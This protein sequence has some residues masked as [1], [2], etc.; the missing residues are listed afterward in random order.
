MWLYF[1]LALL[2]ENYS[3][4]FVMYVFRAYDSLRMGPTSSI[5]YVYSTHRS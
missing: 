5:T 4:S 2:G 1:Y 3:H